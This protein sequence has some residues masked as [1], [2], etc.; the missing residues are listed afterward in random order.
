VQRDEPTQAEV[1]A[2]H[3]TVLA[4]LG[5][6]FEEHK[7]LVPALADKTLETLL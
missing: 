4:A 5:R 1:D 3:G 2:L 6:I 7:N